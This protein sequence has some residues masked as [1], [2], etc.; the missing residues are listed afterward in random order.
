MGHTHHPMH[1]EIDNRLLLN[2][3]SIYGNRNRE[4]RTCL[5]LS[6]PDCDCTFYDID[7]GKPLVLFPTDIIN[8]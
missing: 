7:T 1:L 6:L 2:A 3:G 4:Q 5:V 8:A